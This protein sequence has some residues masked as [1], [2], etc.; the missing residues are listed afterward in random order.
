MK[1]A[2]LTVDVDT[3]A[4]VLEAHG[5]QS[6]K[7]KDPTFSKVLP[8]FDSFFKKKGVKATFFIMG[9]SLEKKE[10]KEV[11]RELYSHGH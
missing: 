6:D 2:Y 7:F 4:T 5:I 11:A 1:K 8:R 9:N 3:V 10:N